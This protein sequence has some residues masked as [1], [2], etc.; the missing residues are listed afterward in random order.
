MKA[1]SAGYM[2]LDGKT[3]QPP[4]DALVRD[5][6]V[7]DCGNRFIQWL[8]PDGQ[9][10]IIPA[11]IREL[12]S[13]ED[14]APTQNEIVIGIGDRQW[15]LGS[16]LGT[17]IFE[18]EKSDQAWIAVLA[19]L[20]PQPGAMV[21]S[22]N[23]LR[24]L[25]TDSRNAKYKAMADKLQSMDWLPESRTFTRNGDRITIGSIRKVELI[26]EGVPVFRYAQKHALYARPDLLNGVIDVGGGDT[27]ARL[28]NSAGAIE[29]A[30]ELT[31]PGTVAL[32]QRISAAIA[33]DFQYEP[34]LSAIM[35][36]IANQ[37]Y[38]FEANFKAYNFKPQ[39]DRA[40]KLWVDDLRGK[41]KRKWNDLLQS[42]RVGEIL[43]AGGSAPLL[44]LGES[45]ETNLEIFTGG[46]FKV[47][48]N[49][50][51]AN[52]PQVVNLYGMAGV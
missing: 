36:G 21:L 20:E 26:D 30:L 14:A 33:Q 27:T 18:E 19:A 52:F 10:K 29:R 32:A 50:A 37:T 6:V 25:T 44:A 45:P 43:I 34:S 41:L 39:F 47:V 15:V 28:F 2:S 42:G 13:W 40:H 1:A 3:S 4:R 12:E 31:L 49:G 17:A 22:V 5:L 9:P 24:V 46:R 8:A 16:T 38:Q 7:F 23:T 51:I 48:R 11:T 35:D